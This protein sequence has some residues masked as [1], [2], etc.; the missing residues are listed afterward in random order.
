MPGCTTVGSGTVQGTVRNSASVP[1]NGATVTLGS[2][3][4]TTD[5]AGFYSFTGLP[6]GTYPSATAS[7]PGFGSVTVATIV[8]PDGGT[9]TRN[10]SLSPAAQSGCFIDTT[11]GDFQLGVGTKCDLNSSPGG[12]ILLNVPAIDQQNTSVSPTGFGI[13]DTSWA[14][15]TFTPAVS[16]ALTKLDL[17]LFCSGCTT[18]SPN[19]TI[20]IRATAGATPVPTGADL[21]SATLAGF[22]DGG[23]GGYKTVTFSSPATLTAG[24]RYALVFRNSAAFASGT[25]AYTCSCATTGFVNSNPYANGQ[26]VTSSTSGAT[27]TADTT[28][29]G[30]D[31]NFRIYMQGGFPASGTFVSS[32]KDA[33]PANGENPAWNTI[34]WTASTPV[35]TSVQ[36]QAAGSN[37]PFG[38]F[39][40]VGPDGTA[41]TFFTS[42]GSLAQFNGFRYVKYKAL[43]TTSNSAVTPTINDVTVC[44]GNAATAAAT[45]LSVS[46][47]SGTYGGTADLSATLTS[48]GNG[49]SG[50][51][52][53][54]TLNGTGVGSAPTNASGV[55]TVSAASL[56]GIGAGSYPAGVSASFSGDASYL[57][58]GGSAALTVAMASQTITF[59]ALV[60]KTFGDPDFGASG[61]ASSGLT[62]M[63]GAS[64]TCTVTVATV[65]LTGAGS[66]TITAS[67]AG[68]ANYN[69][70]PD[71]PQTFTIAAAK[72]N[73][74]IT[75]GALSSKTF[76]DPDF[77]VSATA[78]S[79]LAVTF[80]GSGNCTV[81]VATV[82]LTGAGS[83]TIT[84]SQAGNATYNPAPDVPQTF[85]IA[86]AKQNQTITFGALANKAFGDPDFGVSATASSGLTVTFGASGT[87]T[88]TVATVHLTGTG[89][90]TITAS[91]A[92]DSNYNAAPDVPQTFSIG[93]Q[94]QTIT[95]G[96]L[97]S[98]TFGNADFGVSATASSGLTVTFGASGNCTVTGATVHL[99][100]AGSCTITA[101]Q[102]G[103]SNY[104]AAPGVPQTF[105]IGKA[106]QTITFG[107]LGNKT[108]GDPDFAVSATASSVLPVTFGASGNCTVTVATVHLT[109]AGS[110]TITASQAGDSNYNA[111]PG[112]PQTFSIGKANQTITFGALG[113][114]TF[115]DPDFAVSATASSSLTA[116]FGASGNCTVTVATVHLTGAGSCTITASQ[117]GDSNY[118]AAPGVPQ[119]F[120]IVKATQTITFGALSSKTFGDAD[121]GVSAT[122]SSG[123]TVTF[124]AS[125]N[126][127]VTVATVHLTGA[128]SCT[129]TAS[130]AG[131][132]NYNAAPDVSQTFTIAAAKQNQTITFG[133]LNSKTFGDPDFIVS[134]TAS[135][136][137]TVTFGATGTCTVTG[138]TVHLTGTG[139]CTITASQAGDSNY[140]AAPDV[141]Q[142]FTIAAAKQ[143]QTI[144]FGALA[145]KTFGDPDFGVSATASS[146]LAVTFGAT[147]NCTVTGTTVHLTGAGSCTI[148]ASQAGNATYNPAPD[149]PQTFSIAAAKQNQTITFGALANKTFGDPDFSVSAM[150]SSGLAVTFGATGNCTVSGAT[151]H[152]TAAGSC[153]ITASQAG[154]ATYNPAPDVPQTFTIAAA[155]QNQTITFGALASKT[156]G[157][158]DFTVSATSSSGLPVF[159]G[160]SGNCTVSGATVHLTAA[161]SCTITASQAGNATYNPAPDVPRTFTIAQANQTITFKK[162]G[163]KK[164]GSP[165]FTVAATA[166]SGLTVSFAAS[167]SCTVTGTTVHLTANGT[168][169]ITALQP[170]DANY[171]PAASVANSFKV[172]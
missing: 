64:G 17:E 109:G 154:D 4:A 134:A 90:C 133:A 121:F 72:Q 151:V 43:L 123:L 46:P 97:S 45:S 34:S 68:D 92:G 162:L 115:G 101:S 88:V 35:N 156:F 136:S 144:T 165:D 116:T 37:S 170:G 42:G 58:S 16:G 91:Q 113:N 159:F 87:C 132:S 63:F 15:Q 128:G 137:L 168:C 80:G 107:A 8:V 106:D 9:A 55:A 26:R 102:A 84:A 62:V 112:V 141:P 22:N 157:S 155:I 95:F 152:L 147:G 146:G 30:R 145:N 24:T 67:Q 57:S 124:G 29:G 38:P 99:T 66:C 82:H 70:A 14:G 53:S 96:G 75:F 76:G 93:K 48:G 59:G 129:I 65:H 6:A 110:C 143:N 111:A 167:G 172:Q 10:F 41:S 40:F 161:G 71:V 39:S 5:G 86:A 77:I 7:A 169:T 47:A 31:L 149:V 122:A 138:A 19:I 103:D 85:S 49:V 171:N 33:N 81:T 54:F 160:A 108:F 142:T 105:S 60:N 131:D 2:R 32:L 158:P 140:N 18:V 163:A 135:S 20:S 118:N 150:A 56:A 28:T 100:G 139:S 25:V 36:F 61:T 21:A 94:N 52:V 125:G 50:K 69:A 148:T 119:T 166:S 153:T 51:S 98:K 120:S 83:C 23:G 164:L 73:Q 12:V 104:N 11:Q 127:T 13:S 114:K 74:T 27:W 1:I 130:Q 79:G 78:S 44:F 126:C 89:S 117:A 3:T